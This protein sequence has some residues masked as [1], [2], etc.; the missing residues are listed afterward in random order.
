MYF[1]GC[2]QQVSDGR[3]KRQFVQFNEH[4]IKHREY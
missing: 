3:V 2:N 1:D 4:Q